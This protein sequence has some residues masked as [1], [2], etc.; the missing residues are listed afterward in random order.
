[1]HPIS[2]PLPVSLPSTKPSTVPCP[3]C[4]AEPWPCPR[5]QDRWAAEGLGA[6]AVSKADAGLSPGQKGRPELCRCRAGATPALG[7][8]DAGAGPAAPRAE[9]WVSLGTHSASSLAL[10]LAPPPAAAPE[11]WVERARTPQSRCPSAPT[12]SCVWLPAL[13]TVTALG[14]EPRLPPASGQG[15]GDCAGAV[16]AGQI[17]LPGCSPT[18]P[19]QSHQRQAASHPR[20][21][22]GATVP[23]QSSSGSRGAG[24][25]QQF[26]GPGHV[27]LGVLGARCP[28]LR[29]GHVHEAQGLI[30]RLQLPA[31][32]D[33]MVAWGEKQQPRVKEWRGRG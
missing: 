29:G 9:H 15:A 4:P 25:L 6:L 14:D 5:S 30:R 7:S 22:H 21:G 11:P 28:E 31:N 13:G 17:R 12:L 23:S 1:M 24:T 26:L 18:R 32:L 8:S 10:S 19:W 2:M 16:C 33:I 20:L 3:R 27:A